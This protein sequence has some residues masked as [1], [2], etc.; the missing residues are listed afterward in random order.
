MEEQLFFFDV[1]TWFR[2]LKRQ[3]FTHF[4]V[5]KFKVNSA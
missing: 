2:A 4:T 1:T 3:D 5:D